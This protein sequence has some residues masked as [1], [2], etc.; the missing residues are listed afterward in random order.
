MAN[1]VQPAKWALEA[2]NDRPP[3]TSL[4]LPAD[5][6]FRF[7]PAKT[8]MQ[9]APGGPLTS[10]L[11]V[12]PEDASRAQS[13]APAPFFGDLNIDQIVGNL[14]AGKDGYDLKPFFSVP[15]GSADAIRYRHDVMR[16][17]EQPALRATIEEFAR[18]MLRMRDRLQLVKKSYYTRQKQRWFLD[19]V[20]FYCQAIRTL[21][22]GLSPAARSA[23]LIGISEYVANYIA[24]DAFRTLARETEELNRDLAS[25]RYSLTIKDGSVTA[26]VYAEEADYSKDVL[27]TFERFRQKTTEDKSD[28]EEPSQEMNH[29]EA[30]ILENV[31]RLYPELF[32]RL[33]TFCQSRADYLD[34]TIARFDREI[35]FYL[36]CLTRMAEVA[37][38]GVAFCYPEILVDTKAVESTDGFDLALA[39]KLAGEKK[40]VVTNSFHLAGGER[41]FVVSGPNQ[42]GKTTFARAF[43]QLHY[44]AKLGCPVPGRSARLFL[45]DQL[46]THFEREEDVR[47]GRGKLQDDLV[48]V[49]A[50]LEAATDRSV[51]IM[52]E[53]FTST[54]LHDAVFLG[55][56]VLERVMAIDALGV[57]VTFMDELASL[58]PQTV[59]VVS[60]VVPENPAERTFQIVRRP[61][62]GL[63]YAMAIAQKYRLTYDDLKRRLGS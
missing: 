53:I 21:G 63:A 4:V 31:A 16:D 52:N 30:A 34:E 2:K 6:V 46:F 33:T 51:I 5:E 1:D 23:G 62:D 56:K 47:T 22:A 17:V 29:V 11:F 8:E 19:A 39:F 60:T 13:A 45:F 59:S 20:D 12:D 42:G 40:T 36:A 48:R 24:G 26:R 27:A 44:L 55:R 10:V 41:I 18:H 28:A 7:C 50:I 58:G 54:A 57:C 15:L 9:P 49:H 61:A 43:G 35:Q 3:A 37:R 38:L 25:V 32:S 14:T